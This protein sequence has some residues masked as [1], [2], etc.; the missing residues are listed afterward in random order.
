MTTQTLSQPQTSETQFAEYQ[1]MLKYTYQ[2]LRYKYRIVI[3]AIL[4]AGIVFG[5]SWLIEDRFSAQATVAININEAP[6]GVQP[7]NYR[8][9]NTIGAIEYDFIIDGSQSNE[10][11]RHLARM[12][13]FGFID[14]FITEQNLLPWLYTTDWDEANKKWKEGVEPDMREA[15]KEFKTQG[16]YISN[17]KKTD[18]LIIRVTA[19]IPERAAYLANEF[20]QAFNRYVR[21]L[22]AE[23]LKNRRAYL[24]RRLKEVNNTE[25]HRSIYRLLEAQLAVE[26]LINARANY[27][28]EMIQPATEPLL[29]SYPNRTKW[30]ALTLVGLVLMGFALVI[31]IGVVSGLRRDLKAYAD[32]FDPKPIPM[33]EP[34]DESGSLQRE[35]WV[36]K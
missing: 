6:G 25:I 24:E 12:E 3:I 17:D 2:L 30:T 1:L 31:I 36:E 19:D 15:V 20:V 34:T 33:P 18:L 22:D 14:W 7:K 8:G 23:E 16:L 10:R 35:A 29:E 28:L 21:N 9:A 13:S 11:E 27:P 26:S 5:L 32:K 4:G